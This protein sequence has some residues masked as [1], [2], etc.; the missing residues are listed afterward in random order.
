MSVSITYGVAGPVHALSV[1]NTQ[2]AS[3]EVNPTNKEA[4]FA[5][6]QNSGAVDVVAIVGPKFATPA[7]ATLV[8]PVDGTPTVPN[9]FFLHA[10]AQQPLVISVP[11]NGFDVSMIG[12]AAG[13]S[14][15]YVWPVI[16]N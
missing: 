9:A 2:H 15:V 3:V 4:C 6:F 14:I 8:F 13:P 11:A 16:P 1:T 10:N 7:N 12:A 5:A